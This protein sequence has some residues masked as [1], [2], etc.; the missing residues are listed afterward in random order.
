VI[1][2]LTFDLWG[3]LLHGSPAYT[4]TVRDLRF[5]AIDNEALL[6]AQVATGAAT[7]FLNA[8]DDVFVGTGRGGITTMILGALRPG[9]LAGVA[10]NDIGPVIEGT[11]LARIKKYLSQRG[12]PSGWEEAVAGLKEVQGA[13]FPALGD[14]DWRALTRATYA[15]TNGGLSPRFDP[16]LLR[17]V[18]GIDLEEAIPVLWAQFGTLAAVPVLSIRGEHSDILSPETV[19]AM[20]A[21]HPHFERLTVPGQGHAPLLRDEPTLERI[22]AFARRCETRPE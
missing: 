14:D 8:R 1:R 21:R 9:L 17:V 5:R 16:N 4:R 13:H 15:E 22:A 3:T 12:H 7:S 20:A 10:L 6:A 11:G 18:D 19:A 2:A